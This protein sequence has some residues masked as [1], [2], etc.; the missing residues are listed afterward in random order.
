MT[1]PREKGEEAP[2]QSWY[3]SFS[4]IQS[5]SLPHG[6][7]LTDFTLHVSDSH[8]PDL[9]SKSE[10]Q[11]KIHISDTL[12]KACLLKPSALTSVILPFWA[13]LPSHR[14]AQ[15]YR[16]GF[17]SIL[18]RA[19]PKAS[20]QRNPLLLQTT[21][22]PLFLTPSPTPSFFQLSSTNMTF[23]FYNPKLSQLKNKILKLRKRN[24]EANK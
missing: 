15:M 6:H 16:I 4:W 24:T 11:S 18:S 9:P 19:F 10:T 20:Q 12:G 17:W 3:F 7:C 14:K 23:N 22:W 21:V 1:S 13:P 2:G 8:F 5:S